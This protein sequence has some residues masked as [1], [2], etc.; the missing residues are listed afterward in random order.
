MSRVKTCHHINC[1]M[2]KVVQ[3]IMP[4][5][6]NVTIYPSLYQD[7]VLHLSVCP[8]TSQYPMLHVETCYLI[9]CY[10]MSKDVQYLMI[11]VKTCNHIISCYLS[12]SPYTHR[13]AKI[14]YYTDHCVHLVTMPNAI[15]D[16]INCYN[17][18]KDCYNVKR[19][20]HL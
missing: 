7:M 9:S 19:C 13:Y 10:N 2:S 3:Y 12:K 20:R 18:S 8:L 15:C 17:I 4:Y 1:Y 16:L 14:W 11:Y 5:I 6:K